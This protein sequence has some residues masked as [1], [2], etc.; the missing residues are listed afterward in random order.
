MSAVPPVPPAVSASWLT[1]SRLSQERQFITSLETVEGMGRVVKVR[2]LS[3]VNSMTTMASLHF[4]AAAVS[5]VK[6]G[7]LVKP[8]AA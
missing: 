4:I 3:C 5:S 8:S 1:S 2:H 7:S 6:R